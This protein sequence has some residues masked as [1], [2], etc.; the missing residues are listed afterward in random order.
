MKR[1]LKTQ[2]RK[3]E[4]AR[5]RTAGQDIY[6]DNADNPAAKPA[7]IM[8]L[9]DNVLS[10]II[11]M[12]REP[13]R[14]ENT[15]AICKPFSTVAGQRFRPDVALTCLRF[16]Y[17][18]RALIK[19]IRF[20]VIRPIHKVA[21]ND[22]VM[23]HQS[24][25]EWQATGRVWT[26][27]AAATKVELRLGRNVYTE[28]ARNSKIRTEIAFYYLQC[29]TTP[30]QRAT[31][32]FKF[33]RSFSTA[34][35]PDYEWRRKTMRLVMT[36]TPVPI[37]LDT[38]LSFG[39]IDTLSHQELM[40]LLLWFYQHD[41][42]WPAQNK[43]QFTCSSSQYTVCWT[44]ECYSYISEYMQKHD[45]AIAYD[46]ST[47]SPFNNAH[48]ADPAHCLPCMARGCPRVTEIKH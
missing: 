24:A 5:K 32:T 6:Q 37:I 44:N 21:F 9:D 17:L 25:A 22:L 13:D 18:Q 35:Y 8:Q 31:M 40:S 1:S 16:Y 23:R 4:D 15:V 20:Q 14:D 26:V 42:Q 38:I 27:M 30:E 41:I 34:A 36:P 48:R 7:Y 2:R 45:I 19:T 39:T 3:L 28:T 11:E 47:F 29:V 43:P 12:V 33:G 10:K 46:S